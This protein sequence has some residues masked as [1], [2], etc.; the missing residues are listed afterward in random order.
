VAE[1]PTGTVTFL[2]TDVEGSTRLLHELGDGYADALSEHR[3]ALREC[4]CRHGGVEVDTQGDAFFV[5]FARASDALAAAADGAAALEPGPIRVR[6][7][8]HTGEPV[9]TDEGYVG[10]DVHRAARIASA[11]HG[12]QILVSQSTRDLTD[13]GGL[14]DLGDHRLKDLT[15]PER[16]YQLGEDD[17]PP[18]KSLSQTNLPVQPTALIGRE[19]ELPEVI[20]LLRLSRLLTLTGAGGSGKTRLALQAAAELVDDFADG[21]WFIP[22]AGLTDPELVAA[23]VAS[24]LGIKD[25]LTKAIGNKRTLLVLD[26]LEQLLPGVAP[27]I[28]EL[29]AAPNIRVLATSREHLALAAEQ[30]YAVPTLLL[31]DA[32]AL[33]TAR[34]RQLKPSYEP[35]GHVVEIAR[36]LDGLPLALE[37]AAARVKVLTTEQILQ[38]LG[39]SLDLLTSGARDLPQRQR[40]LRTTIEWSYNLL[41]TAERDLYTRLA[42]FAGSFNFD[43]AAGVCDAD[44]DNLQSLI[45]KSL[46]RDTGEGRFFMLETIRAH[47]AEHLAASDPDPLTERHADHYLQFVEEARARAREGDLSAQFAAIDADIENVRAALALYERAGSVEKWF[48]LIE[49]LAF[50]WLVRG[51]LREGDG[52]VQ[53]ALV[54]SSEAPPASHAEVLGYGADLARLL[55]DDDR[56]AA[57][58]QESLAL[59][60]QLG[61]PRAV[62]RALHEVGETLVVQGDLAAAADVFRESIASAREAGQTGAGTTINLGDLALIQEDYE[63]AASLS[64]EAIKLLSEEVDAGG[65]GFIAHYNLSVALL[66][67]DQ[68]EDARPVLRKAL[69]GLREIGYVEGL[70]WCLFAAAGCLVRER[71]VRDAGLLVGVG[72]AM[73]EETGA[74]LG[75]AETRLHAAVIAELDEGALSERETSRDMDRDEALDLALLSLD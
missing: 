65:G 67:L 9:V 62:A 8:V 5:A 30:E 14:R 51:Q 73:L 16:I 69:E 45:D 27:K 58:A 33:F 15:A 64:K 47:A 22:L 56:A 55:G 11:G 46:V 57:Y 13:A 54:R 25:D 42:I 75:P 48:R 23:T 66:H 17:F 49:A 38:R 28:A 71:R 61:D 41:D 43:A 40:T 68:V 52:W 53:R 70:A 6:M 7:G 74:G 12:G 59:A 21:V 31:D 24:T 63:E 2:F 39:G 35:D 19:R 3:K 44:L 10:L 26:N 50:Y 72:E 1:L 34:A 29:L 36:R 60:R 20:R 32:V 4:F 18:L 37:L